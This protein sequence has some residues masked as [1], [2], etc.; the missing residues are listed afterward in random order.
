MKAE[1][2]TKAVGFNDGAIG[3]TTG[4]QFWWRH[5]GCGSDFERCMRER[6]FERNMKGL[7]APVRPYLTP[8]YFVPWGKQEHGLIPEKT[9][10]ETAE[11]L[12]DMGGINMNGERFV[13][14]QEIDKVIIRL[15]DGT[16]YEGTVKRS[17]YA[18]GAPG[19]KGFSEL[20]VATIKPV[21]KGMYGIKN[22]VFNNPATVVHWEDGTKTVVYCRDNLKKI[23]RVEDGKEVEVL[24]PQKADT[25][26]EEVGLA[27]AIVKKHY[28]N[29]GGYNNIFRKF[30]PG[31]KEREK[32]EKKAAA[33][34]KRAAR[35]EGAHD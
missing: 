30:I 27:M 22:V 1:E 2:A 19:R 28:G 25:Y 8:G 32:A 24:K 10:P 21:R 35:R 20:T 15:V 12:K 29:M 18:P 4:G 31:M 5:S 16:E 34:A 23:T 11:I 3:R 17:E 14:P 13:T 26:S 9:E 6:E 7:P 33:K